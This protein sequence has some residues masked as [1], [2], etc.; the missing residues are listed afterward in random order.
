MRRAAKSRA[1]SLFTREVMVDKHIEVYR[2]VLD[3]VTK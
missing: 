2:E 3:K 1:G